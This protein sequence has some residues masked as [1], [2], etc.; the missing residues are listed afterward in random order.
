MTVQN[1]DVAYSP[2]TG[3]QYYNR[4]GLFDGDL[5]CPPQGV[6]FKFNVKSGSTG[7]EFSDLEVVHLE[8]PE[9]AELDWT[10]QSSQIQLDDSGNGNEDESEYKYTLTIQTTVV[11]IHTVTSDPRIHNTG[12]N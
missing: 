9:Y 5:V 10:V 7:W 3:I 6:S 8:G 11:P 4:E 2:L 1:I 12:G